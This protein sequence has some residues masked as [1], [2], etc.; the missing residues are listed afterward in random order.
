MRRD[1]A[2]G[3]PI[4]TVWKSLTKAT[5]VFRRGSLVLVGAGSGTGKSAF[6]L[7]KAIKSGAKTV[8]HTADSRF[9]TQTARAA[10]IVTGK[11]VA[12]TLK[13]VEQGYYFDKELACISQIRF[14]DDAG[15]SPEYVAENADLYAYL[16]GEYPELI[17]VDNLMDVV[18]D[19]GEEGSNNTDKRILQYFKELASD[20]N[21]CVVVLQHLLGDYDDGTK[22]PPLSAL[23]NKNSKSPAMVLTLYRSDVD[24][25]GVCIVKNRDGEANASGSLRVDLAM[26][27]SFMSIK[28]LD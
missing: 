2:S 28:D 3:T 12:E 15:P 9:S 13:A 4:P 26:D 24:R 17:I 5:A 19:D 14:D 27:L 20:T 7:T 16:H 11:P 8:Y 6:M 10:S 18:S 21:A 22:P 1:T 25:L 23:I